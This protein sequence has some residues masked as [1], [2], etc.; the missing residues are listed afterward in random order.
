MSLGG[1]SCRDLTWF[2]RHFASVAPLHDRVTLHC[3]PLCIRC[4]SDWCAAQG[5]HV[6]II[7]ENKVVLCRCRVSADDARRATSERR[8]RVQHI[9]HILEVSPMTRIEL[10]LN[11]SKIQTE[12]REINEELNDLIALGDV[13]VDP[14]S[15]TLSLAPRL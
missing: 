3:D 5:W 6:Y 15:H 8:H 14:G 7:L 1:H 13:V 12:H 10:L 9:L 2:P 4:V 11:V